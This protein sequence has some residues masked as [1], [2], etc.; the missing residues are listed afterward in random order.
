MPG[1]KSGTLAAGE[2]TIVADLS[3][4]A[5]VLRQ[6]LQGHAGA[7]GMHGAPAQAAALPGTASSGLAGSFLSESSRLLQCMDGVFDLLSRLAAHQQ[8]LHGWE[9]KQQQYD[10][11]PAAAAAVAAQTAWGWLELDHLSALLRAAEWRLLHAAAMATAQTA[12]ATATG[13]TAAPERKAVPSGATGFQAATAATRLGRRPAASNAQDLQQDWVAGARRALETA[14]QLLLLEAA[15][16]SKS[17]KHNSIA[18]PLPLRVYL[19]LEEAFHSY[20][21]AQNHPHALLLPASFIAV[22]A[23]F[24]EDRSGGRCTPSAAAS[25]LEADAVS[26]LLQRMR[27]TAAAFAAPAEVQSGKPTVASLPERPLQQRQHA[28][29]MPASQSTFYFYRLLLRVA[30]DGQ[31][32]PQQQHNTQEVKQQNPQVKQQPQQYQGRAKHWLSR[33]PLDFNLYPLLHHYVT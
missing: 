27:A 2:P 22:A 24:A 20:K 21:A 13:A 7:D 17:S 18:D 32:T 5:S 31:R 10:P 26:W 25:V 11:H 1:A 19:D 8:Q 16:P 9:Y 29:D 12:G 23:A 4:F 30:D 6:Q 14:W 28:L 3:L 33:T 15:Q